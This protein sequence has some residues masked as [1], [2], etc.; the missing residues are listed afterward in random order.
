M[1]IKEAVMKKEIISMSLVCAMLLTGSSALAQTAAIKQSGADTVEISLE[2][3]T[4]SS[5]VSVS[6]KKGG[7]TDFEDEV[8]TDENGK[9]T[10]KYKPRQSS[11]L[12]TATFTEPDNKSAE[13]TQKSFTF[14]LPATEEEMKAD[15]EK[16]IAA[17]YPD[18]APAGETA[19]ECLKQFYTDYDEFLNVMSD[20][21]YQGLNDDVKAF[22]KITTPSSVS[23]TSIKTAFYEAVFL[24]KLEEGKTADALKA[25]LANEDYDD[26]LGFTA[27]I[28]KI[29][30]KFAIYELSSSL[31]NSVVS[32]SS[33]ESAEKFISDLNFGVFQTMIA[34]A[35]YYTAVKNA[36]SAYAEKDIVDVDVTKY[37]S[38]NDS[39]LPFKAMMKKSYATYKAAEDAFN[40]YS[41]SGGTSGSGSSG[42]T[43]GGSSSGGSSSG[44]S[45]GYVTSGSTI[46][47]SSITTNGQATSTVPE[48][49]QGSTASASG[50]PDDVEEVS[51]ATSFIKDVYDA[52]IMVGDDNNN[53]RPNDYITRAETAVLLCKLIDSQ[54]MIA[55]LTFAD[56]ATT[57]WFFPYV[58][59]TYKKGLFSG[60]SG[61]QFS[62]TEG[63]TREEMAAVLYRLGTVETNENS[64]FADSAEISEW[65]KTAVASLNAAGIINGDESGNF[66]P[67]KLITRAEAAVMLSGLRGAK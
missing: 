38:K 6:I 50:Y 19:A 56:V 5:A 18:G 39:T 40:N 44:S 22:G 34:N 33:I 23:M 43:S 2:E 37:D 45:G 26:I 30:G 15:F 8:Y 9:L 32:A 51:W 42:G 46:G 53:F 27:S 3:F 13:T 49:S 29:N 54:G 4:S 10:I 14:L 47:S 63:I 36:L 24:E 41:Y 31:A 17:N 7:K 25:L 65:A 35:E 28:P 62:P 16:A 55:D 20:G 1:L 48:Y 12:Y 52:N 58:S 11:G 64:T 21:V 61:T 57:D 66:N 59:A 67:K 60:K